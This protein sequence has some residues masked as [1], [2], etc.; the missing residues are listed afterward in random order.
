M[1]ELEPILFLRGEKQELTNK[2]VSGRTRPPWVDIDETG[3]RAMI[4]ASLNEGFAALNKLPETAR[5]EVGVPLRME[6]RTQALAKSNR[7]TEFLDSNGASALAAGAPGELFTRVREHELYALQHAI[8]NGSTQKARYAISTFE[9]V[10]VHHPISGAFG[11]D[12]LEAVAE[13]IDLAV[14]Q[15]RLIRLDLFP[16]LGLNTRW[17]GDR[18]LREYLA[19]IGYEVRANRG[20]ASRESLYVEPTADADIEKLT[21]LYGIR[22]AGVEPH[23]GNR[24]DLA[25]QGWESIG[26]APESVVEALEGSRGPGIVGILDTGI[27][28]PLLEP[29]VQARETYDVAPELDP[30]H[31]TFVAGL[32]L[33]GREINS[34]ESCFG[35]DSAV[36]VDAQV[37]SASGTDEH[38]LL[39]RIDEVVRKHPEVRVWNCSF[40][41]PMELNPVKYSVFAAELDRLSSELGI[42]FVQAAGNYNDTPQR[43]WPPSVPLA[44]GIATPAEAVNSLVVGSLSH[45]GGM[46]PV[47]APAS[48]SRR[49]PGFGGQTKPDVCFW[50][51][52]FGPSGELPFAGIRSILPTDEIGESVGTSFA[53][54]LVSSIAAN[55]W[56]GLEESNE[57]AVSPALV[58]GL[59]VH[60]ASL[61]RN[62]RPAVA[63]RNYYGAGVPQS[64]ALTLFEDPN[65][66]TTIH[67]VVLTAGVEWWRAPFPVPTCLTVDV[68]L[69]AEIFMTVSFTPQIDD[70]F[71]EE[72]V[73]TCVE[74][75]FGSIDR[76]EK[77]PKISGR[78]PEDSSR[79]NHPWEASLVVDGKWS[80]VR[81][82]YKRYPNGTAGTEWG[83]KV[84]LLE[85]GA[86]P[87]GME[88]TAYVFLTFRG[89]EDGLP[90]HADGLREVARLRLWNA[91]VS[92]QTS[93]V[94]EV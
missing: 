26:S 66:F 34:D 48:Y 11:V 75:S 79:G 78:V 62:S 38:L 32:V 77:R 52:D 58:K 89:I 86:L 8:E 74:A 70:S 23:F 13:I 27:A 67:E 10:V 56:V 60:S 57:F 64:G 42:L 63:D 68:K 82:H 93:V 7:P 20:A 84:G 22:A 73:R 88:Q 54:P 17:T 51:G 83:L 15:E 21:N 1:A 46:S 35:P 65:S 45:R 92:A 44:D 31:G 40:A 6:L 33:A 18:S 28:A 25:P 24:D 41:I 53:A 80:P 39:E 90:V 4:V 71:E 47:G 61:N 76:S 19:E 94:V 50:S 37:L 43:T 2:I 14:E 5:S 87:P 55:V 49:G 69:R 29:W 30:H 36:L 81:T 85:R 9:S 72:A 91:P 59:L 16:W 3:L 12:S